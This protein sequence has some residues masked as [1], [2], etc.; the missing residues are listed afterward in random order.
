MKKNYIKMNNNDE[1]LSLGNLFRIIKD[2]SK[3][4]T[5]ALQSELFCILFDLE[6]INDT[7]VNNYCVGCR[8]IGSE[9]KQ[10]FLNKEKR[11]NKNDLEFAG[12]IIG[13][14]S[15]VD[16]IV[17]TSINDKINFIN[18]N[19]SAKS[20]ASKLYNLAKNDKQ[21]LKEFS[22]KLY[23]LIN[24]NSIYECLVEELL[25]IVLYKK[26]P[27]Y[28]DE[29]KV[30]VFENVL[31]DTS[32]SSIDLQEYLSLKLRE[33]INYDYSMKKLADKGNAYA[34]F[35]IG[36]NEY[37]GFFAGYPRYSVAFSYLDRAA[38]LDHASANYMIGNMYIR[39]LLGS[40][41]KEELEKGYKYLEKS[42]Q[43]GNV[44]A[45]NL[46][47][48]MYYEGIY[49]LEKNI[50]KA[51]EYYKIA[52]DNNYAYAM[53]NMGKIKEEQGLLKEA[54]DYYK[55]SADLGESWAC[56]KMGE[57]YRVI[58]R[59]MKKAYYY[60]NRSLD[61]NCRVV[62]YYAYYN[63]AIYFYKNGYDTI[64]R[65]LNKYINYLEL[66]SSNGVLMATM[67]LFYYYCDEYLI[68]KD[69]YDKKKIYYYKECIEANKGYTDELRVDIE[70]KL[71]DIVLK[72]GINID[73]IVE[74]N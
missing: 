74:V 44:A 71:K 66:A 61:S 10:I 25:F 52:L 6:S 54:Y 56:N 40:G 43:L 42:F 55:M 64:N 17:Y 73:C 39:K 24:N 60:Y 15:I 58:N 11:Y 18:N 28:E 30:E 70:N 33:G 5:S 31:N 13:L 9:Y 19:D 8:S 34:N 47:G 7:T 38:S 41:S 22:N 21:I 2:S 53:N 27:V 45:S 26:Q 62:C 20:I 69:E 3:N 67:E 63:L 1:H 57:Y 14:L 37:Y 35:E 16:G 68:K 4:K 12:N 59:D 29:L 51:I 46:I 48:N 49:P 23:I 50:D 65:D 32:I 36:S 72:N